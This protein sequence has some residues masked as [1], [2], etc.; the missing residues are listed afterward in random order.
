M[1]DYREHADA[2]VAGGVITDPWIDGRPRFAA[3]PIVLSYAEARELANS[4]RDVCELYQEAV[5]LCHDEPALLDDF[6]GLSPAQKLMF[7]A[8][9]PLWHGIARADVFRTRDGSLCIAELNCDTPTGEAE[10][11]VTGAL[12]QAAAPDLVDPNARLGERFVAMLERMVGALVGPNAARS[13][14]LI[15]PTEFTEDL[16][17]VR[18][19]QRWLEERGWSVVLGSPY[20]LGAAEDDATLRA[21]DR[22]VS[23]LLRH[24]KTDWWSERASAWKND[25]PL[26]TTP[27]Y[28]PL[29]LALRAQAEGRTAVVNPLG[30]VLPQNKRTMAFFWEHI[31][32]FTLRA[33]ERI[34]ALVPVT[35][36]LEALHPEMLR[37]QRED[38]V[39]KSDYGAEGD[40]VI[41]GRLCTAA[42][43]E[44]ARSHARPERW[45]A[46][47]Y[48]DAA[49]DAQ[50]R[51][52]N[53]GVFVVA[54]EPA[55]LYARVQAGP[56]DSYALSTPVLLDP[57]QR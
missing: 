39:L 4:A 22:R 5:E 7:L 13:A 38:W 50:G 45:I 21:F 16:S 46:Q 41:I 35:S 8:S 17:L 23:L 1:N 56:T 20:N 43:W 54:G 14:A 31:H 37:A 47:R 11:V 26:D 30:A 2:I 28:E 55:G 19:Y 18:L 34:R 33:Q 29:A 42:E 27:L 53:W 32:R 40:E 52:T 9:R 49:V 57:A 6:F 3:E 12:A 44:E 51:A 24:Y 36:R 10:A 48:F 25:D 15:Y